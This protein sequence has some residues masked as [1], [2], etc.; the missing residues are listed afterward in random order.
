MNNFKSVVI[1]A[2]AWLL[3][4]P[5]AGPA[6]AA[7]ESFKDD[8]SFLLKYDK[9]LVL[10]SDESGKA[11]VAVSP[12]FQGRVMTSAS[13]AEKGA[14][15]G[16]VNRELIASRKQVQHMNPYGGEDRFWIGPEGGQFSVFFAPGVSFDLA[17][18]FTPAPL[19][20]ESSPV[21]EK[22]RGYVRFQRKIGLV[23]YSNTKFDV[24][25]TREIRVLDKKEMAEILGLKP[26][27]S[28]Q[29]VA[30]ESVNTLKNT[31]L[32][33]WNKKTGLLSI[34]ILGMMNAAP[35]NTVVIPFKT[36]PES[37]LGPVIHDTY[38][39][40]V[41]ADRLVVKDGDVYFKAD[42]A[43]RSKFG[44]P[45]ARCKPFVGSYDSEKGVLTII[46][47]T[48]PKGRKD[49]VNSLWELQKDPF[50]G[51]V[52]NSYNDGPASPGAK[53]LGKFYELESSSPALALASGESATHKHRTFHFQGPKPELDRMARALLGVGL[54]DI[55]GVFKP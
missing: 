41:P 22:G 15:Y 51:D 46:Q 10:L 40:K 28:V 44:V 27:D 1:F 49:Y 24:E 6:G 25:V 54:D 32:D 31:G 8:V 23:N 7:G 50:S 48:L 39:G 2:A 5:L 35:S 47:F 52:S 12:L 9:N 19:D 33:K 55:K 18:W 37:K 43:C 3:S 14:S 42:G 11:Q 38:F 34:W 13:D 26:A 45:P 30:F 16:W 21:I 29:T 53:Q 17:H 4:F 20:T 36:G